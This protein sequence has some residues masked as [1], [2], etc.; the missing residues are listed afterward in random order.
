[1]HSKLMEAGI[2]E[3][4]QEPRKRTN[5]SSR[6]SKKFSQR[7][8]QLIGCKGCI[9]ICQ[10]KSTPGRMNNTCKDG[11]V[12]ECDLFLSLPLRYSSPKMAAFLLPLHLDVL[13]IKWIATMSL[14]S[15]SLTT[16]VLLFQALPLSHSLLLYVTLLSLSAHIQSPEPVTFIISVSFIPHLLAYDHDC[17][18]DMT[19]VYPRIWQKPPDWLVAFSLSPFQSI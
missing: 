5:Y 12:N 10:A 1:M 6:Q 11:S 3:G 19:Y 14:N 4:L 13:H 18:S 8:W 17:Y 2:N 16:L 7:S 9:G 15:F